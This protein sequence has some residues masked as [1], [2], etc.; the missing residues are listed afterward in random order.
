MAGFLNCYR[1]FLSAFPGSTFTVDVAGK[2]TVTIPQSELI[3][4]LENLIFYQTK[5]REQNQKNFKQ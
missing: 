4:R 1:R 3:L 2:I 5:S